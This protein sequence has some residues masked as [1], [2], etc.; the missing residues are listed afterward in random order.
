[1]SR[2]VPR[3]RFLAPA[4]LAAVKNLRLVA[5]RLV[6]GFLAGEHLDRR[7]GA[8]IEFSQYR[9]YQPGDDPR[10]V[11][12]RVYARSDRFYVRE[13]EVER[14]ITVRL[15]LDA[16][17]SMA[18]EDGG[19][20]KLD[21]GRLLV[22]A[23]AYL[24]DR[25]GDRVSFHAVRDGTSHDLPPR[26]GRRGLGRVLDRLEQIEPSGSWPPWDVLGGRIANAREKE[27]VVIVGDLYDS[28]SEMRRG[29]ATLVA[30]GHEVL[31][32]HLMAPNELEFSYSGDLEFEDLETGATV[33]GSAEAMRS[34]YL[35]RLGEDLER[36]RVGLLGMGVGYQLVSLDQP[37]DS[38]LRS[39]LLGR[40]RLP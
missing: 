8:G 4:T 1:V 12:W 20:S 24:A 10:R 34:G 21:Y 31:V 40:R 27:L 3:S 7:P 14:D 25:Q 33:R 16:T 5:R 2:S 22:A 18:H 29:L 35:A 37:V 17:A 36:W 26:L 19:L 9:S 32:L 23:L 39:F 38:A 30:L 15:V 11:D 13:S 28:D 6:E